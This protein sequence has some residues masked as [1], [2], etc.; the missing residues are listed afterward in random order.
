MRK[1]L[2]LI[3]AI[4]LPLFSQAG[5][6][7]DYFIDKTLRLDYIFTGSNTEVEVGLRGLKSQPK[8]AGKR[9]NLAKL[10]REGDVQIYMFDSRTGKKIF[11]NS[12]NTLFQEWQAID[13]AK[14]LTRSFE[15]TVLVP[16][17]KASV[18]ISILFR[19][20]NGEYKEG[21]RHR[22]DPDDIMIQQPTRLSTYDVLH[23]GGDV[24]SSINVVIVPEGYAE[25][26]MEDFLQHAETTVERIFAHKPFDSYRDRFNFY[27]VTTPSKDSGVSIPG[28][29]VWKETLADS[30]F[31]TFNMDRYLTTSSIFRIHDALAGVPYAHMIILA[32]T[33]KYGG[34]GI[35][36]GYAITTALHHHF[37][38]VVVHE[39][40]HSFGGLADEY[41]DKDDDPIDAMYPLDVEP[42]SPN[43]TS[44]VDFDSKWK[45][46]LTE[47]V[48]IPT[49]AT[50]EYSDVVGLFE[51]G[52]YISK[53]MYRPY[54]FC[55]MRSTEG[56]KF[57]P[58]CQSALIEM[59]KHYTE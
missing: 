7:D 18:D 11:A 57:C 39:F 14:E 33:D 16:C 59:I 52:G 54:D 45:D 20:R 12:F 51:G 31:N 53:G 32:N 40:G 6:F 23:R 25:E 56:E 38:Y 37:N 21:F 34:G 35:F 41:F 13:E 3:I 49:P 42:W 26:D 50:E 48:P 5:G 28:D 17:P 27:A 44:L 43:I 8:W 22:V 46:M 36:N 10:V 47:G 2:L 9:L 15:N 58:V 24:E 1:I 4:S 55:K 29:G 19:M 30:H